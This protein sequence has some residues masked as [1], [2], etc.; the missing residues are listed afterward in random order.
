MSKST[1]LP[2]GSSS[3]DYKVFKEIGSG[4]FGRVMLVEKPGSN[5]KF[6]IKQVDVKKMS[7]KEQDD[8][9]KEAKMLKKFNHPN[10]VRCGVA[11][12]AGAASQ[13]PARPTH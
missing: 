7:K 10:I 1:L 11:T 13:S 4:A 12:A 8:A 3:R 9:I 5:E 2:L 6:C